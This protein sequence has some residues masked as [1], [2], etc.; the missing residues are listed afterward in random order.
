MTGGRRKRP[1][2]NLSCSD[3]NRCLNRCAKTAIQ[4][5]LVRAVIHVTVNAAVVV[6]AIIGGMRL[7]AYLW[8]AWHVTFV[9]LADIAVA[10]L[11][12]VAGT[13]L[14]AL[15]LE[16]AI[17]LLQRIP[18]VA[19]AFAVGWTRGFGRYATPDAAALSPAVR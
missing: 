14:Q 7:G 16:R 1:A 3:C 15:V 10:I 18:L 12:V 6:A 5:S 17:V 9:V 4:V 19:K 13:A 11:L 8:S 2:W